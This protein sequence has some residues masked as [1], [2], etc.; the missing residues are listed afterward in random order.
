MGVNFAEDAD[1]GDE[2]AEGRK[3]TQHRR[4]V[5]EH[6]TRQLRKGLHV[7]DVSRL[8]GRVGVLEAIDRRQVEL[9]HSGAALTAANQLHLSGVPPPPNAA[10]QGQHL[11]EARVWIRQRDHGG[12]PRLPGKHQHPLVGHL[13]EG[14]RIL[15]VGAVRLLQF[16]LRL[17]DVESAELDW[18]Q[19]GQLHR[20]V[21][22]DL[23]DEA[24]VLVHRLE[25]AAAPLF[26]SGGA[27]RHRQEPLAL[28]GAELEAQ[29]VVGRDPVVDVAHRI[30]GVKNKIRRCPEQDVP[31]DC[32]PVQ[33]HGH[34]AEASGPKEGR[35]KG[36]G[37]KLTAGQRHG[38]G[39][40]PVCPSISTVHVPAR[41]RKTTPPNSGPSSP[42]TSMRCSLGKTTRST[43][44]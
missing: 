18:A 6:L 33:C 25:V 30:E 42:G 35:A 16:G 11:E 27:G 38:P 10:A 32:A 22:A 31:V 44:R 26:A 17:V 20:P 28:V 1:Q 15:V 36:H 4:D 14:Q 23:V 39:P 13:D 37:S 12:D 19:F 3:H 29:Q 34:G 2:T 9:V 21:R 5:G 41:T 24:I 8:N 43:G 40:N 7:D